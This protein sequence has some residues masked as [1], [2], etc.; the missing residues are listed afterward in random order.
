MLENSNI[1]VVPPSHDFSSFYA[2]TK[3][4]SMMTSIE[5]VYIK[6]VNM[7]TTSI[8]NLINIDQSRAYMQ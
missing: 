1:E 7:R 2:Y 8:Q 6:V 3:V 5:C 4:V